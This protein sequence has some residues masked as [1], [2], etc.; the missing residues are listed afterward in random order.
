M[1]KAYQSST[2]TTSVQLC[3][4]SALAS[5]ALFDL[6]AIMVAQQIDSAVVD[7][8]SRPKKSSIGSWFSRKFGR[9]GS[10]VGSPPNLAD[11]A[12]D[13]ST[14]RQFRATESRSQ[15]T[16]RR[17][18]G[19][20]PLPGADSDVARPLVSA[21]ESSNR[22]DLPPQLEGI[23]A[24]D[25]LGVIALSGSTAEP[26]SS[27]TTS[28]SNH[29]SALTEEPT[30]RP[31]HLNLADHPSSDRSDAFA[32]QL[33]DSEEGSH[34]REDSIGNRTMDTGKS[35][36]STKQTTLMSLDTREPT[37]LPTTHIAQVRQAEDASRGTSPRLGTLPQRDSSGSSAVQLAPQSTLRY[38]GGHI[39]HSQ[40]VDS[41]GGQHITIPSHSRPHPMNNP[42]PAGIPSDNASVLTLASSTAGLSYAGQAM[43]NRSQHQPSS[44]GGARSYG[45]SV[46]GDR[47]NSSDTY[48]SL[49]ALPPLSRRGSDSSSR[50]RESVAASATGQNSHQAMFSTTGVNVGPGAPSDRLSLHRTPSQRT[51]ATQLSLPLSTSASNTALQAHSK[52]DSAV[53]SSQGHVPVTNVADAAKF[54]EAG[55]LAADRSAE[56][57]SVPPVA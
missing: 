55:P 37:V 57:P 14:K 2:S 5:T 6:T 27:N 21:S 43:S 47:R 39:S 16:T 24:R 48:A 56:A 12:A 17:A 36:A 45:G 42:H 46:M 30:D 52:E 34:D 11:E 44:V 53:T 35:R 1:H 51:V 15:R 29:P 23:P 28:D 22:S 38:S 19:Q 49:K 31:A 10:E 33:S 18:D 7:H 3:L 40:G 20:A 32:E 4:E 9:R 41:P 25:S 50:T 8:G 54:P 26:H 13:Q